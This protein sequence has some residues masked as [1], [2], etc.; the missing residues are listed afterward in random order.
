MSN[1]SG[2]YFK[3][4]SGADPQNAGRPPFYK[5][6]KSASVIFHGGQRL[7]FDRPF[8]FV[9]ARISK[10]LQICHECAPPPLQSFG[11]MTFVGLRPSQ[12]AGR[13]RQCDVFLFKKS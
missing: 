13:V 7:T 6:S 5:L 9:F 2:F 4:R 1:V 12:F 10:S 8:V 3:T 11:K